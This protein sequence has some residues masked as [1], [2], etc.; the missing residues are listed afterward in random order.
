MSK[1][2][3]IEILEYR[4]NEL[5]ILITIYHEQNISLKKTNRLEVKKVKYENQLE[6]ILL[7]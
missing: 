1:E 2:R 5:E 4:I 7:I 6:Q 3:R